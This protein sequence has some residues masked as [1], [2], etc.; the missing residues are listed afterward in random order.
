MGRNSPNNKNKGTLS[1][2]L[3]SYIISQ[4]QMYVNQK[5]VSEFTFSLLHRNR[6]ILL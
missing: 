3:N 4:P 2:A 1:D 6:E 5:Q